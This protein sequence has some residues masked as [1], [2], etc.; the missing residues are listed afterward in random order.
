MRTL[1]QEETR[2]LFSLKRE[3]INSKLLKD[4]F[5]IKGDSLEPRFNTFDKIILP[6]GKW[7]NKEE[8]ETT[9]GRYIFNFFVFPET[10]LKY[11]GYQNIEIKKDTLEK[12]EE[13][14]GVL[15]LNDLLPIKEYTEYL[16]NGE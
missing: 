8:I 2:E 15:L 14:M 10:F 4:Y 6:K 16:N 12:I 9:I 3:E 11:E 13:K 5:A 1:S 7:Y